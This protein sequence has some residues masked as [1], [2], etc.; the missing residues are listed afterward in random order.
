MQAMRAVAFA[1]SPAL[2]LPL[3]HESRRQS[4]PFCSGL[5]AVRAMSSGAE[6]SSSAATASG[7]AVSLDSLRGQSCKGMC[8]PGTS[9]VP[10]EAIPK[11]LA[12]LPAWD[13]DAAGIAISR[14]F[15]ARNF[16]AAMNFLNAVAEVAEAEGHHPDLHLTNE[17]QQERGIVPASMG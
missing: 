3:L 8:G 6:P 1:C 17:S 14:G 15:T 2:R 16:K 5:L 9:R 10:Q 12:H 4:I 7:E 11:Y 13:L